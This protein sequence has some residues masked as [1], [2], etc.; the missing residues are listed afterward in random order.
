M[1]PFSLMLHWAVLPTVPLSAGSFCSQLLPT[2]PLLPCRR[3]CRAC[4]R[5]GARGRASSA[6]RSGSPMPSARRRS[7]W[8][9]GLLWYGCSLQGLWPLEGSASVSVQ[10]NGWAYCVVSC[11]LFVPKL[12]ATASCWGHEPCVDR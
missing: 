4:C 5:A 7:E 9:G 10:H 1:H 11:K 2:A 6:S 3:R 8:L 12:E